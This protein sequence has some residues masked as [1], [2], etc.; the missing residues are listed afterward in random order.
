MNFQGLETQSLPLRYKKNKIIC[1]GLTLHGGLREGC[2]VWFSREYI[3]SSAC[4][5]RLRSLRK[6]L[7][8]KSSKGDCWRATYIVWR[9]LFGIGAFFAFYI[10]RSLLSE[11]NSFV[12]RTTGSGSRKTFHLR[13][14]LFSLH[15]VVFLVHKF[16]FKLFLGTQ[17][18]SCGIPA[19]NKM[20]RRGA[21]SLW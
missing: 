17:V 19:P 15:R 18:S 13:F 21:I 5:S 2:L 14:D 6:T 9:H 7:A 20:L 1:I 8:R 16:C 12:C 11:E 4:H 10:S 3:R